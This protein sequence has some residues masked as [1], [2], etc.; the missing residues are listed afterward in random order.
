M[1]QYYW[2]QGLV[3]PDLLLP[4]KSWPLMAFEGC[5]SEVRQKLAAHLVGRKTANGNG[6]TSVTRVLLF[7]E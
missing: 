2:V 7:Q 1:G 3:Q 6:I 4:Q 5:S